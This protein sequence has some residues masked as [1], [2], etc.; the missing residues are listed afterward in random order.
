MVRCDWEAANCE[1]YENRLDHGGNPAHC[2]RH[3]MEISKMV[4]AKLSL[5]S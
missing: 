1:N 4:S 3:R 5:P 2:P